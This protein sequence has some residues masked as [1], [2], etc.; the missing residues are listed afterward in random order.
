MGNIVLSIALCVLLPILLLCVYLDERGR[1]MMVAMA[2]GILACLLAYYINRTLK[3]AFFVDSVYYSDILA[4]IVE[5]ILKFIPIL[6]FGVIFNRGRRGSV[7]LAFSVGVGFCVVENF[8]YLVSGIEDLSIVWV[9]SRAIGTGLM[10]CM[11]SA[12]LGLGTFYGRKEKRLGFQCI[13][14]SLALS[15]IYHGLYNLLVKSESLQFIGLAIPLLTY[16][17]LFIF[18]NHHELYKL[19]PEEKQISE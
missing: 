14:A 17:L 6:V 18:L 7:A 15:V 11:S 10:H 19:L 5:E 3:A 9:I 16:L 1:R 13:S 12:V 4:P 8:F 2:S